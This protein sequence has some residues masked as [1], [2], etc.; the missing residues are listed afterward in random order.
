MSIA[1]SSL[2]QIQS[3]SLTLLLQYPH[4]RSS[5]PDLF[6]KRGVL[7]NFAKFTG[8][9]SGTG[10]SSEFCDFLKNTFFRRTPPVTA[11]VFA[12][13]EISYSNTV[14]H[15]S[16]AEAWIC[17]VSLYGG[18]NDFIFTSIFLKIITFLIK[19]QMWHRIFSISF[20]GSKFNSW[21]TIIQL[22]TASNNSQNMFII[23]VID[24]STKDQ[25]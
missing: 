8:V 13:I 3:T 6:C 2:Q 7:K 5:R 17:L 20:T 4:F 9:S 19:I 15:K 16:A 11:L 1:S 12:P 14:C 24:L 23:Y 22:I 10:V 18:A 21:K 25:M